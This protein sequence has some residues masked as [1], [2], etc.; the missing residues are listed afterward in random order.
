MIN[1]TFFFFIIIYL[2]IYFFRLKIN[3]NNKYMKIKIFETFFFFIN[4]I[5]RKKNYY[6]NFDG[7]GRNDLRLF[8]FIDDK[9]YTG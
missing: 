3:F 1:L 9:P 2:F 8:P 7:G 4:I 6:I 5:E